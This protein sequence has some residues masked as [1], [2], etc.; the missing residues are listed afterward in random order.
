MSLPILAKHIRALTY[1]EM[2]QLAHE[3]SVAL[4]EKAKLAISQN[5]AAEILA[6][7]Q[8]DAVEQASSQEEKFLREI[9]KHR[10]VSLGIQRNGNGWEIE[11]G[12]IPGSH[13]MGLE[14]RPLFPMMLDQIVALHGLKRMSK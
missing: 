2:M 9:F 8:K 10:R 7:L 5:T 1:T 4:N 13:A 6:G 14:L 11:A 3:L 12:T